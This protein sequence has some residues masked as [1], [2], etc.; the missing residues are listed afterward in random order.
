MFMAQH[1]HQYAYPVAAP[2]PPPRQYSNH[3]NS[4]AFS[5]S[6]NPDEDWTKISDLAER[7]RIQNRIAQ[8]NYRKKLKRR[9]EDLERR[10]G[11]SDEGENDKPTQIASTRGTSPTK[12]A[13][14]AKRAS[15]AKASKPAPIQHAGPKNMIHGQ[16]TPP[17]ESTDELGF[18]SAFSDRERS[19]TPP[20]FTYA[21]YPAPD[22]LLVN[23][24]G[25][26]AYP[27]VSTGMTTADAYPSYLAA[28][29]V[30]LT[31]PSMSHFSD[32]VKRESYP[33]DES[34][35]PYMNFG[36]VGVPSPYDQSNPHTPPLS[37]TFD[38]SANCSDA[39]YDYP[40]T[41]PMSMPGSPGLPRQ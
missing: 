22:E 38:H 16:F 39:G 5:S 14:V 36:F 13:G 40:T 15:P 32:A 9:L 17:M 11:S 28:S 23:P 1:H 10:A 20:M 30:P 26:Q 12:P 41:P 31:L 8:R 6:A 24:Y 7:R 34:M 18:S 25:H 21:N 4:S 33:S 2:P 19:H 27:A 35:N 37:H 3:G 29:T